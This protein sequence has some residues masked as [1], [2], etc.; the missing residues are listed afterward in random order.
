MVGFEMA[1]R[2]TGSSNASR[3]PNPKRSANAA[4]VGFEMADRLTG[5]SNASRSPKVLGGGNL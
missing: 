1:D 2:L 4:M 3:S 5:S